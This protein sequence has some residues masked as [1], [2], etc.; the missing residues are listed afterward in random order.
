[1]DAYRTVLFLHFVSLFVGFGAAVVMA[2]CLFRLR[3]AATL[4]DALP[5]GLVAGKTERAFPV[6]ILGLFATGAYMTS[7]VWTWDTAWI[8]VGIAALVVL[9][10]TGIGIASRR[11]S[12]L[13][14]ALKANGPGSLSAAARALTCDRALWIVT[15]ANPGLVLAVVWNM[16][17]K[18]GTLEAIVAVLVGYAVGAAI[19]L[20]FARVPA[21][22]EVAPSAA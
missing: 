2:L 7:D 10:A 22:A 8:D 1:M 13:E 16:T 6:A 11:A 20:Q 21:T 3:A 19:A 4:A 12:L 14:Q 17:Q 5:W 9:A 15:F 18:P